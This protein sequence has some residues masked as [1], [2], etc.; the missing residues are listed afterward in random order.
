MLKKLIVATAL[1]VATLTTTAQAE[2][3]LIV[4]SGP[5][6]GGATWASVVAEQLTKFT[7]EPIVLQHV[8][9]ARNIPGLNMFHN[10]FRFDDKTIVVSFGSHSVNYLLEN[11]DF[12]K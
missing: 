12:F 7:D 9:G 6:S 10:K 4:P 8:P 2:Y 5:G 11:V 1:F 3:R